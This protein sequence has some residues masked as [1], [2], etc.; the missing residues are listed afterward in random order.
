LDEINIVT[1]IHDFL[2]SYGISEIYRQFM[3]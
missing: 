1:G 2:V 3:G